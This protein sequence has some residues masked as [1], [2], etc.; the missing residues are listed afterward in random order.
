[1]ENPDTRMMTL[2][3]KGINGFTWDVITLCGGWHQTHVSPG[4]VRFR[5][6]SSSLEDAKKKLIA[7]LQ[8]LYIDEC[9]DSYEIMFN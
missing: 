4:S 5:G 6:N 7:Y 1:M 2:V 3:Y 8:K 9:V